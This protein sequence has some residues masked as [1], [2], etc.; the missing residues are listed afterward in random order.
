M[1]THKPMDVAELIIKTLYEN[2]IDVHQALPGMSFALIVT[3]YELGLNREILKARI[4][5]DID[6]IYDSKEK[7]EVMQ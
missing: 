2:Q 4:T 6:M 1:S 5:G 3:C 7:R